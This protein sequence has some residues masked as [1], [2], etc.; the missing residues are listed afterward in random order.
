M[1]KTV[2]VPLTRETQGCVPSCLT[3]RVQRGAQHSQKSYGAM[4]KFVLVSA[5]AHLAWLTPAFVGAQVGILK[6]CSICMKLACVI[7]FAQRH[8]PALS[9]KCVW[10]YA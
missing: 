10:A 9:H 6:H 7:V 3:A 4:I 2:S 5:V 1:R 8:S